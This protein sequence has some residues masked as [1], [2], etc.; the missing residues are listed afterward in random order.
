MRAPELVNF[1][2]TDVQLNFGCRSISGS[3]P[4]GGRKIIHFLFGN[5]ISRFYLYI[6]IKQINKLM[7]DLDQILEMSI[8]DLM[9]L[10]YLEN[11]LINLNS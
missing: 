6:I 2:C 11:D 9:E 1:N 5:V 7:E 10:E 4:H 3:R 8:E